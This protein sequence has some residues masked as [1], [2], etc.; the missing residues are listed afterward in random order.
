MK[1]ERRQAIVAIIQQA[2]KFLFVKRSDYTE[3]A[4][5]Y[6]CPVGGGIEDRET[7]KEALRREVMEEV[8]LNVI[9]ERKICKIT[10]HDNRSILHYW[11]TK[12]IS[13]KATITSVEATDI[14]WVAPEE[15]KKLNP[16]FKEDLRIIDSLYNAQ[17][18]EDKI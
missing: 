18:P 10:S 2:D 12:I 13:G 14:K 6:W 7:Q 5:G 17:I 1:I 11:T 8:G 15:M 4:K 9:A 3:S 16:V